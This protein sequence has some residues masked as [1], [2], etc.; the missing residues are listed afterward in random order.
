MLTILNFIF[1]ETE[2]TYNCIEEKKIRQWITK[3]PLKRLGKK[4]EII[5]TI[6]FIIANDYFN[7]KIIEVDGGLSI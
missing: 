4:K 6:N 1:C 5:E 7:G 3:T 2:S